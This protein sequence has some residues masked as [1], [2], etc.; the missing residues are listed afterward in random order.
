MEETKSVAA[1]WRF[2]ILQRTRCASRRIKEGSVGGCQR[3]GVDIWA[4]DLRH[5]CYQCVPGNGGI[6]P[7]SKAANR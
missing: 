2:A 7:K 3:V 5:A 1:G 4:W 6:E